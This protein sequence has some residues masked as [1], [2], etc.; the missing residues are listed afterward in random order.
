MWGEIP[1]WFWY[2]FPWWLMKGSTSFPCT[3]WP[4]VWLLQKNV[5]SSSLPIFNQTYIYICFVLCFFLLLT[6]MSFIYILG[7]NPL[8]HIGF[9]YFLP[10]FSFCWWHLLPCRSFL[11]W[12]SSSYWFFFFYCLCFW[13]NIQKTIAK[14]CQK[15]FLLCFLLR[16]LKFQVLCFK[17]LVPFEFYL[18]VSSVK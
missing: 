11:A 18:C 10:V 5:C 9:A 6:C 7:I 2:A 4:S 1:L 12:C 14:T 16:V 3:C 13:C 15:A 17:S 8:L